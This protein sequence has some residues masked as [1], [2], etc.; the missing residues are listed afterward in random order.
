MQM[1]SSARVVE[2]RWRVA[3]IWIVRIVVGR[4]GGGLRR[5]N[6][7]RK[8]MAGDCR[9]VVFPSTRVKVYIFI[10][11]SVSGG[12]PAAMSDAPSERAERMSQKE[13]ATH[14]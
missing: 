1:R 14:I 5:A 2:T 10:A 4:S 8:D 12:H 7:V 6:A 9:G 3:S 11:S 13:R